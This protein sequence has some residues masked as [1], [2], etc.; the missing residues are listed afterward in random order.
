MF[1][2]EMA[3]PASVADRAAVRD[4]GLRDIP[5]E[6]IVAPVALAE[7]IVPLLAM[8]IAL[9]AVLLIALSV[10]PVMLPS[11][12]MAPTLPWMAPIVPVDRLVI[13][14]KLA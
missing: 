4:H 8:V 14:V 7:L 10:P 9:L 3:P 6:R 12:V 13:E 11:L 5:L 1:N 2:A